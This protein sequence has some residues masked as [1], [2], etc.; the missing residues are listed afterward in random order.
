MRD[1]SVG[2]SETDLILVDFLRDDEVVVGNLRGLS[3]SSGSFDDSLTITQL[4]SS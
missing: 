4:Q 2:I 3:F 1:E